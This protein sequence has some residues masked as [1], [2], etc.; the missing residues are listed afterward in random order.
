MTENNTSELTDYE[1]MLTNVLRA[2]ADSSCPSCGN[3]SYFFL[4]PITGPWLVLCCQNCGLKME[5]LIDVLTDNLE[6]EDDDV[7]R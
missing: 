2:K 5:Y 6:A 7:D 4:G 1:D 3:N